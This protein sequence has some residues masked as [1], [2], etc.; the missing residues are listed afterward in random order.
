LI[1]ASSVSLRRTLL[2][3]EGTPGGRV[4]RVG[5]LEHFT[6]RDGQVIMLS[7]DT[8]IV[9]KYLDTVRRRVL[10]AYRLDA[11]TDDGV[12]VTTPRDGYFEA[13]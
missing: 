1:A 12:T 10:C 11:R 9:G 5:V 4:N 7:T 13:I 2:Q 3:T 6:K 8:E